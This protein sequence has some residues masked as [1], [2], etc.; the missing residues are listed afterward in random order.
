MECLSCQ[1]GRYFGQ[2]PRNLALALVLVGMLQAVGCTSSKSSESSGG[3]SESDTAVSCVE[4]ENPYTEGTGHY[5]G[6]EWAENKGAG[7]CGGSS[8]SFIEGCEEFE[9]QETDY[10]Q[11]EAKKTH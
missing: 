7:T 10:Q 2:T 3:T 6:Y 11:C 8:P 9:T 1:S 4:P 5:A